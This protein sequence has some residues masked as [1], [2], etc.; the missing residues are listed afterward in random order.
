[1]ASHDLDWIGLPLCVMPAPE[2][3]VVSDGAA[4][5]LILEWTYDAPVTR[6]QYRQ[7]TWQNYKPQ[8]WGAWTDI[9]NSSAS[10]RSYR[11]GGLRSGGK[12]YDYELRAIVGTV[13]GT[14][15]RVAEGTTQYRDDAVSGRRSIRLPASQRWTRSRSSKATG[16]QSDASTHWRMA[17]PFLTE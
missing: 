8:A 12:A 3:I 4:D 7:R 10:T 2:L 15:S 13:A 6:W 14:S 16:R 5:A 9:P 11:F 17:S 1:M